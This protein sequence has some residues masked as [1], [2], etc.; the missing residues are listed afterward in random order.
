MGTLESAM[1]DISYEFGKFKA[2]FE[3]AV[4][5]YQNDHDKENL[6]NAVHEAIKKYVYESDSKLGNEA[7]N[8]VA[9][10]LENI[11][12]KSINAKP[13]HSINPIRAYF[14][15]PIMVKTSDKSRDMTIKQ[16]QLQPRVLKI[17]IDGE[18]QTYKLG[19]KCTYH[20]YVLSM[21]VYR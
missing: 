16:V 5:K 7:W 21:N 19:G 15:R 13:G 14:D 8:K 3:K 20:M 17:K 12:Y 6:I 11:G 4:N 2:G 10:W 1:Q 18:T 9:S